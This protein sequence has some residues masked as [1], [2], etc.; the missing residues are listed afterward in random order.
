[1]MPVVRISDEVWERLKEWAVPLEDK[2]DD[3]LRRLLDLADEHKDCQATAIEPLPAPNLE[4]PKTKRLKKG[5]KVPQEAYSAPILEALY[6]MGGRGPIKDVLKEAETKVR[7]LLG[8]VDYQQLKGGEPRWRNTAMWER[9]QLV[10][11]GL[12][13][14]DSPRGVWELTEKGADSV[15]SNR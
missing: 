12:L 11:K 3:V 13:K 5:E 10:L 9:Y 7:H 6:E 14:D 2:P 15:A 8:E 1:M 4:A